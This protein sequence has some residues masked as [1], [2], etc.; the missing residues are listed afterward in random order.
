M[1]FLAE[2]GILGFGLFSAIFLYVAYRMT[3]LI[4]LIVFKKY[5]NNLYKAQFFVLLA[6]FVGMFP[7]LP[8]GNYFG[9]W[10]L[11]I[12]YLPFGF[13]LYIKEINVPKPGINI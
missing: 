12:S 1:Q 3:S 7:L 11:L 9:N 4:R 6:V 5:S 13:Y 10:L 2:L 8:S